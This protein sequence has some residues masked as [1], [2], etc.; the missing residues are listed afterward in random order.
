MYFALLWL[1]F[2]EL[3]YCCAGQ[4]EA[5]GNEE[6]AAS[7]AQLPRPSQPSKQVTLF[8]VSLIVSSAEDGTI[9]LHLEPSSADILE[10]VQSQIQ[11][12]GAVGA[13][14][15][16]MC[17]I[18]KRCV[19]S[20]L[21]LCFLQNFAC[22]KGSVPSPKQKDTFADLSHTGWLA[23]HDKMNTAGLWF[24]VYVT[25]HLWAVFVFLFLSSW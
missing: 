3:Q 10:A 23:T 14:I 17:V 6:N 25:A 5:T 22:T 18:R 15:N 20:T 12:W 21:K 24:G 8:A 11:V 16:M 13:L 9:S 4:I 7:V 2:S 1:E 19:L